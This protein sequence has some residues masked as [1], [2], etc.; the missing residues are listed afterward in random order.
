ML[1]SAEVDTAVT[2]RVVAGAMGA[3]FVLTNT[4]ALVEDGAQAE[5]S[6]AVSAN[7]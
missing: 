6:M 5:S 7:T 3:A 2:G 1:A 4:G